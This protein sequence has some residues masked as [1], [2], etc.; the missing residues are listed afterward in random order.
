MIAVALRDVCKSY[1]SYE[2]VWDRLWEVLTK[3]KKHHERVALHP[4]SLEIPNGQVV[5]VVG[6][7]GAGK[8]TLL[9]LIAGTLRPSAGEI[10]V[11]GHVSALLELGAGFHPEMSGRDN[12]YLGASVLGLPESVIDRLFEQIV[13]FA[14]LEDVIDEPVKTYSS[15][16]HMR[17][18]FAVA[19]AVDPEVLILDETLSVGDGAFARK[20]FEKIIGYKKAGKSILFCSHAM[21]QVEAVCNR[22]LWLDH[23]RVVMD[24]EPAQ[25]INAYTEFLSGIDGSSEADGCPT[26]STPMDSPARLTAIEVSADGVVGRELRVQCGQTD[27][28]VMFGFVSDPSLPPPGVALT[29]T[30]FS[31]WAVT[32]A[33]TSNDGLVLE[34]LADGT[35]EVRVTFPR[36]ALLK[37]SYWINV[38]LL[39]EDGIHVYDQA[40]RVAEIYVVQQGL[41]QGVVSL[42]RE[43]ALGNNAPPVIDCAAVSGVSTVS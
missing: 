6:T 20:S 39:S 34:R 12:V 38:F 43:W 15:G 10:Q 33:S 4:V 2:H 35:G 1:T 37:G 29:I 7:N 21:Y 3:T 16:M 42:P 18:A 14:G 31:G 32:S 23:G 30:G 17:L 19:T 11:N 36:L 26:R 28:A 24:A 40:E 5:G 13:A 8:S 22:V 27:L 25:V 41:E 9:K